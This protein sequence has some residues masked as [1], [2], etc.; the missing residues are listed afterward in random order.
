[1]LPS[2]AQVSVGHGSL[3]PR[4]RHTSY[5][6]FLRLLEDFEVNIRSQVGHRLS[7]HAIHH[8]GGCTVLQRHIGIV[9]ASLALALAGC[10]EPPYNLLYPHVSEDTPMGF[11][12]ASDF[13]VHDEISQ[14][15]THLTIAVFPVLPSTGYYSRDQTIH[16]LM[17]ANEALREMKTDI[18]KIRLRQWIVLAVRI[19]LSILS[20][21][22]GGYVSRRFWDRRIAKNGP[23]RPDTH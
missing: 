12:S 15:L 3:G 9:M 2:D 11:V 5:R 17:H 8:I 23:A 16:E 22:V 19:I 10:R 1:M 13:N 6:M 20:A 4:R 7:R 21:G 14:F 18:R